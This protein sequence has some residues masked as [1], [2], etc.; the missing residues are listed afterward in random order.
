MI[1]L[2]TARQMKTEKA[3]GVKPPT[4]KGT[5][6]IILHAGSMEGF[7]PNAGLV[8]QA[9]NDGDYHHQMNF[10]MFEERFKTKLFPKIKPYSITV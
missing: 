7:V 3:T 1:S 10:I 9:K 5:R 4:G 8:F 6:L 2:F